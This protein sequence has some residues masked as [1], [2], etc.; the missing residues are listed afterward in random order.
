MVLLNYAPEFTTTEAVEIAHRL[1]AIPA[2]AGILP[3]ERDQ[4]FLLTL[5]D[6]E[7]RVLKI[8]NARED[9]DLLEAENAVMLHVA[10]RIAAAPRPF[11]TLD[12]DYVT[13]IAGPNGNEHYVRLISFL[14]GRPMGEV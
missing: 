3:S 1:Y 10:D 12:G 6:G 11:P 13:R 8:A 5:E 7:K 2:A 9:L 14:P 4:N